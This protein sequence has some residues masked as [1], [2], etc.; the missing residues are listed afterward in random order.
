M[1]IVPARKRE[2]GF[3]CPYVVSAVAEVGRQ[4]PG[5]EYPLT[6]RSKKSDG[7]SERGPRRR[8]IWHESVRGGVDRNDDWCLGL[9]PKKLFGGGPG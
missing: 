3:G 4:H 2:L 1:A 8:G 5:L 7:E 9:H 6:Q